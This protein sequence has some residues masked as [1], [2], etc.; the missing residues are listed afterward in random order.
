MVRCNTRKAEAR[1]RMERAKVIMCK[2]HA[3]REMARHELA[4]LEE[5]P[6]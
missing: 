1:D 3:D 6:A 5:E 4:V 2:A